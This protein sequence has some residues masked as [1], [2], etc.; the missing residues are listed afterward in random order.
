MLLLSAVLVY[1][2]QD[3]R[4]EDEALGVFAAY[5][6]R[7]PADRLGDPFVLRRFDDTVEVCANEEGRPPA[8][9]CTEIQL[10]RPR[11]KQ[12]AGGFRTSPDSVVEV[13]GGGAIVERPYDCFGNTLVCEG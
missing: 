9:F 12:V 13:E 5:T 11:G 6:S 2:H 4:P 1:L 10:S 8:L 7:F 3:N